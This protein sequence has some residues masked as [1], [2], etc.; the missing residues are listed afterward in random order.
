MWNTN[1]PAK[2]KEVR[3]LISNYALSFFILVENKAKNRILIIFSISVVLV[4]SFFTTAWGRGL[5]GCG[6]VG[7]RKAWL[8]I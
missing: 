3:L 6:Y 5:V 2:I 8:C 1:D 4:G 7:T